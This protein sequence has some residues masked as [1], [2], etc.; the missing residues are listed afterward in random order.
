MVL[1]EK[2]KEIFSVHYTEDRKAVT[3]RIT[4]KKT[5]A[6]ETNKIVAVFNAENEVVKLN[7]STLTNIG[8]NCFLKQLEKLSEEEVLE[9]LE[10][11]ALE[12]AKK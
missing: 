2:S 7:Q 8:M 1:E 9:Y 3:R 4:F 11:K 12:E 10:K 5:L 6:E